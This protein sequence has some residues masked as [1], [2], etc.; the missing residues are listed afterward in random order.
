MEVYFAKYDYEKEREDILSFREGDRFQIASKADKKWWAAY[1]LGS[2][3]YGYVPS[4]Y[5]E[6]SLSC[7]F[8]AG[9]LQFL[10]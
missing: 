8:I 2:G 5:L 7:F 1:A 10:S 4:V 6:V 3:E 9:V